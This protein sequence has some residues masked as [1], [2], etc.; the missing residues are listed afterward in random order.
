MQTLDEFLAEFRAGVN[1]ITGRPNLWRDLSDQ[2]IWDAA[3][4]ACRAEDRKRAFEERRAL[5]VMD[6]QD[7]LQEMKKDSKEVQ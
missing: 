7:K 3:Q 5:E 2:M 1:P 6:A 4:K